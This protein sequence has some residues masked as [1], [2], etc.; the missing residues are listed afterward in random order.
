MPDIDVIETLLPEIKNFLD[1]TWNDEDLEK[2]LTGIIAR[3][4][5]AINKVGGGTLDYLIEDNPKSLLF[6]YVMY[7]REKRQNEFWVDYKTEII[8]LQTDEGVK[9]YEQRS[10]ANLQ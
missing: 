9:R 4:I 3:G 1:I 5:N 10:A 7:T 2:K 8:G 6:A